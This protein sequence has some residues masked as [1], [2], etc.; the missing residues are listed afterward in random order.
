MGKKK[1]QK[2]VKKKTCLALLLFCFK[3]F[4]LQ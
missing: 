3:L 4:W 1:N 2:T